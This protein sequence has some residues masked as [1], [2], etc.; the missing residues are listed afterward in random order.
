MEPTLMNHESAVKMEA[1]EKYLL[2]ELPPELRDAF[3]EHYFACSECGVQLRSAAEFI[4][5]SQQVLPGM[6]R[7]V[8]PVDGTIPV[9]GWWKRFVPVIAVP[10]FAALLLFA[11]FQNFVTIPQL[12]AKQTSENRVAKSQ[13]LPMLSLITANTKGETVRTATVPA[14]SAVGLYVDV[15]AAP[16]YTTYLLRLQDPNGNAKNLQSLSYAEAQK[17]QVITVDPGKAAG[18]YT[19]IITGVG[20]SEGTPAAELARMQF[21]IAFSDQVKQ[22]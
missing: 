8:D 17:T 5:A 7:A 9:S 10:T 14:D 20:K 21:T 22:D 3:E 2:G 16:E 15:P 11:G 4:G 1:C 18:S 19:L 12:R 13:V 6:T